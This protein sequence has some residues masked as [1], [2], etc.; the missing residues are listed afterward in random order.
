MR[1][2]QLERDESVVE[3]T[4]G[5]LTG[6]VRSENVGLIHSLLPSAVPWVTFLPDADFDAFVTE[7]VDVAQGVA[8]LGT[9]RRWPCA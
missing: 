7:F 8:A 2:E 3:F 6:L 9:C 4:T 1:V 5:L